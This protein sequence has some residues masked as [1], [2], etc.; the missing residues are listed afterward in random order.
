MN[1]FTKT[2]SERISDWGE[3]QLIQQIQDFLGP[4][5]PPPPEGIGDD[6]AV[7]STGDA[8]NSVITTDGLVWNRHFDASVTPEQ[9][10]AKLVKRNLSD[11]AA[12]GAA[13]DWMVLNLLLAPEVSKEWILKFISGIGESCLEYRSKLVGGD[14]AQAE[15]GTLAGFI[16]AG[17]N[18]PRPLYRTGSQPGDSLWVTGHLGGSLR[19]HHL[20]FRPR[21]DEG[22]WLA[23]RKEVHACM[24][25]TDGL[26]KDLPALLPKRT[27][28]SLHP[29][30][31]PISPAVESSG[32]QALRRAFNDGED[33]EL[34]FS[35]AA[36]T[37]LEAFQQ[38]W[39]RQFPHTPLTRIG[40]L[41]QG[42]FEHPFLRH[43]DGTPFPVQP[44]EG[45]QHLRNE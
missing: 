44:G 15:N 29:Q 28:A 39:S 9:A 22:L 42:D 1:P 21:L 43:P 19:G 40:T 4:A 16:T 38:D 34:L 2:T 12:M 33:Y 10:G 20:S 23:A 45:Y 26:G 11:L 31:I 25:V 41:L 7:L 35:L 37:N 18:A 17:G 32:E 30:S 14:I 36:E 5:S 6:A 13:P 3:V 8:K 27:A 24:D